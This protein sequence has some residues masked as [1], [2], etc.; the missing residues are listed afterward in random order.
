MRAMRRGDLAFFY[1]SNCKSPGIVGIMEIVQEASV[2]GKL[3]TSLLVISAYTMIE[4]AFDEKHP[5]F[6]P[7]DSLEKST[8][9]V[10]HVEFRRKFEDLIGLQELKSFAQDGGALAELAT[11]RQSRLSVSKVSKAQ[12]GF[13]LGLTEKMEVEG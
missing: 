4:S 7:R 9:S 5:Y 6:D 1:H 10:V 2:D 12:W 3:S 13:I 11:L 8:W